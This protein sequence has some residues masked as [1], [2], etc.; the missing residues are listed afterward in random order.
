MHKLRF[1][2]FAAAAFIVALAIAA[3]SSAHA[4][5]R[6]PT[7]QETKLIRDCVDAKGGGAKESRCIGLVAAR[8]IK[9]PENQAELNRADCYRIEQ[10]I[11]DLMLN[12]NYK[13][14]Q[15]ELD[16]EQKTKLRDMQRAWIAA[17]DTTCEFY[18][19]K[20]QGS[21]SVPMTASCLLTE[22]AKRAL[23]LATFSGL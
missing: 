2:R 3:A 7:A 13:Q 20:I 19:H 18:Y 4:Q 14:L 22:T 10:E 23:L 16:D 21:I 9:K 5:T 8:C 15:G 12:E 1:V 11:W 6:K 17:R